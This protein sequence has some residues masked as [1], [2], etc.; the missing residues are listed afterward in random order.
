MVDVF[1]IFGFR[2]FT[3]IFLEINPMEKL[4]DTKLTGHSYADYFLAKA[5]VEAVSKN[6]S[7]LILSG[8]KESLDSHLLVFA[9]EEARLTNK[10][11]STDMDW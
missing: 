6:D 10:V 8:P 7:S 3:S 4:P 11:L 2:L 5:F 9:A 1:I